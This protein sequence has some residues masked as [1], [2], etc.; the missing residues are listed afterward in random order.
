MEEEP[1][2]VQSGSTVMFLATLISAIIF[3]IQACGMGDNMDDE[4]DE[5]DD[6]N[7]VHFGELSLGSGSK[8]N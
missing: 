1:I 2:D 4:A 6:D 5:D 8:W 3:L 7:N